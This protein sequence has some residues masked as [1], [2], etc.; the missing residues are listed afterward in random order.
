MHKD[1]FVF[2][3]LVS[4]LDRNKFNYIVHTY[5]EDKDVKHFTYW[6]QLLAWMF[7]Q[8]SKRESLRDLVIVLDANRKCC[9]ALRRVLCEV[10][11]KYSGYRSEW[12]MAVPFG[13]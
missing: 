13:T 1:K 6:N 9:P 2:S 3:P 12:A 7:G 10:C 5:R 4:F 11:P 8:L